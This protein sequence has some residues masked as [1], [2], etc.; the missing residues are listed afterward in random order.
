MEWCPVAVRRPQTTA[1]P[2]AIRIV[3]AAI[4]PLGEEAE[5]IGYPHVDPLAVNESHQRFVGVA[6]GH[7]YVVAEAER[8]LLVDPGVVAGF[9]AAA[10]G[11]IAELRAWERGQR[12][13]FWTQLAF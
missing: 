13:A 12:P 9:S 4:D 5:R 6:G 7:R 3:D 11:D 10:F 1:L 8:I 2:A